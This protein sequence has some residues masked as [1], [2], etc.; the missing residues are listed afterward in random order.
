MTELG[1]K[2]G[3]STSPCAER[4]KRLERTG[5]ITGYHARVAPQAQ[6]FVIAA[7]AQTLAGLGLLALLLPAIFT[8]WLDAAR[9][10]WSL[11]PGLG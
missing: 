10:A 2:I 4:V 11:L 1:E 3:L 7:P 5:V 6:V 8:H 9:A